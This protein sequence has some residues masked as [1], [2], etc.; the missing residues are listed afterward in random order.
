MLDLDCAPKTKEAGNCLQGK[1]AT[2]LQHAQSGF[3]ADKKHIKLVVKAQAKAAE[4][5]SL[6]ASGVLPANASGTLVYT[7]T[8]STFLDGADFSPF[9]EAAQANPAVTGRHSAVNVVRLSTE[10]V[11]QLETGGAQRHSAAHVVLLSEACKSDGTGGA[12][13]RKYIVNSSAVSI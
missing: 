7:P 8:N 10:R 12:Q 9:L 5:T 2:G 1:P 3:K 6:Q 11:D 13:R 4:V